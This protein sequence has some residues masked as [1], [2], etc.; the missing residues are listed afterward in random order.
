MAEMEFEVGLEI[1]D[2]YGDPDDE[3]F[4]DINDTD[5]RQLHSRIGHI[6][7]E[8]EGR[9]LVWGGYKENSNGSHSRYLDT[10]ELLSY[11]PYIDLWTLKETKNAPMAGISGSCAVVFDDTLYVFGGYYDQFPDIGGN[12]NGLYALNLKSSAWREVDTGASCKPL[13]CDKMT[14]WE[15]NQRLYFFAGFGPRPDV[16][17][18]SQ[19]S[20]Q[21]DMSTLHRGNRGWN[22]QLVC[23]DPLTEQWIQV[24]QKGQIPLPRAAHAAAKIGNLVY[25][26]GGRN[27][28][29][30]MKDLHVLN[31]DTLT[32]KQLQ[33]SEVG[34]EG[35]SWHSLTAVGDTHLVL[36]GGY[37]QNEETLSDC[38]RLDVTSLSWTHV[39]LPFTS[40]RLWHTAC[41]G[42]PGEV[43]VYGGCTSNIHSNMIQLSTEMV[44]LRFAPKPLFSLCV[45]TIMKERQRL[46]E[47]FPVLPDRLQSLINTL[48]SSD[49]RL[50]TG[51]S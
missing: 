19:C 12:T 17:S 32:W 48:C 11:N 18:N 25:V 15:H 23:F 24:K 44:H 4:D 42:V 37:N 29:K 43:L 1:V 47:Q 13:P 27:Q 5:T 6:A 30:R 40:P 9:M 10:E 3:D 8:Y 46:V 49:N 7:F 35:R 51:D 14:G 39:D 21:L 20:F 45:S 22:N 28:D 36:F 33:T 2:D 16:P 38:W 34:P 41:L 31:M 50:A 26:F